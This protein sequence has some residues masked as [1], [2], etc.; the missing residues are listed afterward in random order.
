[1]VSGQSTDRKL[2]GSWY[3]C[4][5]KGYYKEVHFMDSTFATAFGDEEGE[6]GV[7][8]NFYYEKLTDSTF[9]YSVVP[10]KFAEKEN[11][12]IVT[13]HFEGSTL[14]MN[15]R[16]EDIKG[17]FNNLHRLPMKFVDMPYGSRHEQ[18]KAWYDKFEREFNHR[19]REFKCSW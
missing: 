11:I 15:L 9:R 14:M 8:L 17:Y 12:A 7:P 19:L 16:N 13:F 5:E 6:I 1:M 4:D 2:N 3:W 18:A 10:P